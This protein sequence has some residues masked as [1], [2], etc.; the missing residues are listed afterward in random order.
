MMA[1]R[2]QVRQSR[3]HRESRKDTPRVT[4]LNAIEFDTAKL[5]ELVS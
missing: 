2:K 4:F 1:Y 3:I 5:L